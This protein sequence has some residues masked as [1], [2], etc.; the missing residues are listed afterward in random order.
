MTRGFGIKL[1]RALTPVSYAVYACTLS[2]VAVISYS[3]LKSIDWMDRFSSSGSVVS[4]FLLPACAALWLLAVTL[5]KL[6]G[7]WRVPSYA[8]HL[9]RCWILYFFMIW[10]VATT[11]AIDNPG[12]GYLWAL[13]LATVS[14][15]GI[16]IDISS[17]GYIEVRASVFSRDSRYS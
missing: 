8:S 5:T 11:V 14:F 16:F 4:S 12:I 3:E 15:I 9:W 1:F 2:V 6:C 10:T 13:T 7:S 17:L